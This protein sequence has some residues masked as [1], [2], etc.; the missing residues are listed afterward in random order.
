ML[1]T[2]KELYRIFALLNKAF[3][4]DK[5]EEPFILIQSKKKNI[6]GTCSV[7]RI[8]EHK[9]EEVQKK[10][11]ITITAENL[12][13]PVNSIV[14]TLLHEM[15]HL[16][17]ALNEI[18]DT[19]NNFVYHNKRF[20]QEA[21]DRGLVITH[22]KTIGWSVTTLK[23]E[24]EVLIQKFNINEEVFSYY[25]KSFTLGSAKKVILNKYQ[26]PE[27]EMKISNYKEVNLI[28]GDCNK[29]LEKV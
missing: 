4:Q 19:S 13:R 6:L 11:E 1:E 29:G 21:E 17:N 28:C 10:Y 20:K 23:P 24:T 27:C 25:R 26:C 7:N 16:H 8:W 12:N 2:S 18:K 14:G 3:F 22:S 15:V 9:N 5:L